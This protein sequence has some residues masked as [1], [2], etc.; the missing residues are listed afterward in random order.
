MDT[1]TRRRFLELSGVLTTGTFAAACSGHS[2]G[3]ASQ[4]TMTPHG[5]MTSG[6]QLGAAAQH[7]PLQA[8]QGVLVLVTLYGGNDGL[9]TVIPASDPAYQSSRPDL[10]YGAKEVL[11]LG[12]GLGFNPAMTGLHEMW[13][14]K[15]CA[16]VRG[17]GYPTP[18]HSHFVS[19]DIWQTASPTEPQGSGWLGRWLDAQPDD[20][21]RA[22]RAV[23]V[24]GTLPPLLGGNSTAGSSLPIGDFHLPKAGALRQGFQDLGS[25]FAGDPATTAYAAKDIGDLFTV[26]GTFTPV[27]AQG[28]G[29]GAGAAKKKSTAKGSALAQQL[30][31]VAQCV[32][33]S[34]PTRVYS[35]S[36]GGFDTHSAEKSTQS[37]L[38]GEVDAALV[39]FQNA[40][41]AGPHGKDV[42][43]VVYTEFGRRVKANANQGT[44][45][46]TAGPVL[47]VGEPVNGGFYG[48]QPSLTDLDNGDLKFT[49][50]FRSVYA[51]VLEKVLGADSQQVLGGSF[52]PLNFV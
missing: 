46:G 48:A 37:Q 27:L 36:L 45:H 50:D 19:M 11:D 17:V 35:V 44:D 28:A 40:I 32:N 3:A 31:I 22:L 1:V 47:V 30:D 8:G 43:T 26:A 6:A 29:A 12:E 4:T 9:N 2:H 10:A 14:R 5:P 7:S 39:D 13:Q 16:V 25:P 23:A 41:A 24:G 42:V 21:V 34:V 15:L 51:T 18:N 52:A 38:W 20:G 33:A 49:T